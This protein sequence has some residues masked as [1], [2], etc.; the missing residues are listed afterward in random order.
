MISLFNLP[1]VCLVQGKR[2]RK[3]SLSDSGSA[4]KKYK[5]RGRKH[6]PDKKTKVG[7]LV[8]TCMNV[9]QEYIEGL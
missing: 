2:G 5:K 9:T 4:K 3:K 1:A 7:V 8:D 6:S